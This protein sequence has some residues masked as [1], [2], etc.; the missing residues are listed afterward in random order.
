MISLFKIVKLISESSLF[1][2]LSAFLDTASENLRNNRSI[3]HNYGKPARVS[4]R[5]K[6]KKL[7]F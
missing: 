1:S 2:V 5:S 6:S 4:V 7:L 3:D